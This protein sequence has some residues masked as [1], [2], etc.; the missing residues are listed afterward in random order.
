MTR[1]LIKRVEDAGFTALVVTVDTPFFGT[2]L[3]DVR[4]RF[5]LPPNLQLANFV[6]DKLPNMGK[7]SGDSS[8]LTDYANSLFDASLTWKDISWLAQITKLPIVVKGILTAEDALLAVEYNA[9][10]IIVSNHGARQLDGVPATVR[11]A[12]N[13]ELLKHPSYPSPIAFITHYVSL[14][15][16]HCKNDHSPR[17]LNILR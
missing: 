3:A 11:R 13:D 6:I 17:A 1:R 16:T 5:S 12:P 7:P 8:G 15:R 10:A 9:S 14:L 4:N 2:R